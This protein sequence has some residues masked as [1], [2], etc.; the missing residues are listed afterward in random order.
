M[1]IVREWQKNNVQRSGLGLLLGNLKSVRPAQGTIINKSLKH[2]QRQ[3]RNPSAG[4]NVDCITNAD[5]PTSSP[6]NAKPHVG[7]SFLLIRNF[8]FCF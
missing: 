8:D 2:I 6:N 4:T 7:C 1:Q 5:A 3:N